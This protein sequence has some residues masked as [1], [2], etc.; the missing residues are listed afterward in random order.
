MNIYSSA[1]KSLLKKEKDRRVPQIYFLSIYF[2]TKNYTQIQIEQR[3]KSLILKAFR[4]YKKLERKSWLHQ[5]IITEINRKTR[6][7]KGPGK[8]LAVFVKFNTKKISKNERRKF[9]GKIN[10]LLLHRK[11]KKEI[12]IGKTF[13]LDQFIWLNKVAVE[14]IILNL[15]RK[16]CDIYSLD[17]GEWKFIIREKNKFIKEK[18]PE[19]IG[20]ARGAKV[21][22]STGSEKIKEREIWEN[23]RFLNYIKR[24]VKRSPNF[25]AGIDYLLIF[26]S[27]AFSK[28]ID[29]FQ[30]NTPSYF[31][32]TNLIL[33]D[34]NI[35]KEKILK[36]ESLKKIRINQKKTENNLLEEAKSNPKTY[37]QGWNKVAKASRMRKIDILFIKPTV[38][39]IGYIFSRNL[40]YTQ[41][42]ENSRKVRNI[43]PWI[44]KNAFQS[45]GKVVLLRTQ[46][47]AKSLVIAA[48]LRY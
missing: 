31:P 46:P 12:Y 17:N 41:P 42:I 9:Q 1:I 19:Y 28:L 27:S 29:D 21:Y 14:A 33:I 36:K 37:V 8:G 47:K 44:V 11:P 24:V 7:L 23:K 6:L 22:F 5:K 20:K 45:G 15:D 40:V 25:Q 3:L 4:S 43:A 16:K 39:K 35:L 18:E 32:G 26:Y 13:D 34:R 10:L 2:P 38:R 48:K 30:K